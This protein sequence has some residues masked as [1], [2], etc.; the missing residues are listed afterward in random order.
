MFPSSQY[1]VLYVMLRAIRS[2]KLQKIVI[3]GASHPT[4]GTQ[5]TA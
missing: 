1:A 4:Y 5:P 2:P 3:C